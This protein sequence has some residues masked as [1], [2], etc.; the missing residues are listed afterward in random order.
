MSEIQKMSHIKKC[1]KFKKMSQIQK[2]FKYEMSLIKKIPQILKI[3][4]NQNKLR[5][6]K[7]NW[8]KSR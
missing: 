7:V 6:I 1:L 3:E 8:G 2:M 4:I 5:Q